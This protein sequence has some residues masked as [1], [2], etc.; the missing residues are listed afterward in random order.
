MLG[1]TWC[2]SNGTPGQR[3]WRAERGFVAQQRDLAAPLEE[4]VREMAADSSSAASAWPLAYEILI[5]Q[6]WPSIKPLACRMGPW[7]RLP[8]GAELPMMRRH[9][10][11]LTSKQRYLLRAA[12]GSAGSGAYALKYGCQALACASRV[13][14][15]QTW[16]RCSSALC[17]AL[18]S[19]MSDATDLPDLAASIWYH[20]TYARRCPLHA[21]HALVFESQLLR[22]QYTVSQLQ[23]CTL[24]CI[25]QGTQ[26]RCNRASDWCV[27]ATRSGMMHPVR[28]QT[29]SY[30]KSPATSLASLRWWA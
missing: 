7:Q 23:T 26:Q 13:T 16:K 8:N 22:L 1:S 6:P 25:N 14:G 5:M 9:S 15:Q 3:G 21:K 20:R 30:W 10:E 2:R 17:E 28:G 12:A 29:S 18:K 24:P 19:A 11:W 4:C 27:H